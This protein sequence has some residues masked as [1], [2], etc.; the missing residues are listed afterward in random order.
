MA[1]ASEEDAIKPYDVDISKLYQRLS[2][3]L[4][5]LYRDE[6]AHPGFTNAGDTVLRRTPCFDKTH[7]A[8]SLFPPS[9]G[10]GSA[11]AGRGA[12]PVRHAREVRANP[13]AFG[14]PDDARFATLLHPVYPLGEPEDCLVGRNSEDIISD[15]RRQH[16]TIHTDIHAGS[17]VFTGVVIRSQKFSRNP[18]DP[19]CRLGYPYPHPA[20]VNDLVARD[21]AVAPGT[22]GAVDR[23]HPATCG[24]TEAMGRVPSEIG[25]YRECNGTNSPILTHNGRP[26]LLHTALQVAINSRSSQVGIAGW[27]AKDDI[28][29]D[30]NGVVYLYAPLERELRV[31][32]RSACIELSAPQTIALA[33][34]SF[35]SVPPWRSSET[36]LYR[37]WGSKPN[38]AVTPLAHVVEDMRQIVMASKREEGA[39][40]QD[41]VADHMAMQSKAAPLVPL[42]GPLLKSMYLPH[43]RRDKHGTRID[44]LGSS[45]A[46]SI[47][48]ADTL[49]KSIVSYAADALQY[50]SSNETFHGCEAGLMSTSHLCDCAHLDGVIGAP[51]DAARGYDSYPRAARAIHAR[52]NLSADAMQCYAPAC[53]GGTTSRPV[54]TA[55]GRGHCPQLI[56]E[57]ENYEDEA[58]NKAATT[59]INEKITMNCGLG[60]PRETG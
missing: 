23:T 12:F 54:F 43:V 17:Y 1:D 2:D 57:C 39:G 8:L 14:L 25:M 30:D 35:G 21:A 15:A 48:A 11:G 18:R 32:E 37:G 13:T 60:H 16:T 29:L 22:F 41:D 59:N 27:P 58:R 31:G 53:D 19:F 24:S 51:T 34:P 44:G 42:M 40:T 55:F 36:T 56:S 26:I 47:T 20:L 9:S 4:D 3:V 10:C 45:A 6:L 49:F 52:A 50:D 28:N 46:E 7:L 5:E 33:D 38:E